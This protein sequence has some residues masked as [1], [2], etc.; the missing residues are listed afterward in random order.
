M[1]KLL[2]AQDWWP[3]GWRAGL[4][5]ECDRL[6]EELRAA[7]Q[8]FG[9]VDLDGLFDTVLGAPTALLEAQRAEY[10]SFLAS[11]EEVGR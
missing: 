9:T 3:D 10:A 6:G 1:E 11:F 8:A 2:D 7:C 5:A 4:D